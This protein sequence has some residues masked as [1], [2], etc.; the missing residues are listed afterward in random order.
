MSNKEKIE[1]NNTIFVPIYFKNKMFNNFK[2]DNN[3][4]NKENKNNNNKFVP[5]YCK[6]GKYRYYNGTM[7]ILNCNNW[8]RDNNLR[9]PEISTTIIPYN[10]K[11]CPNWMRNIYIKYFLLK[12]NIPIEHKNK[13][14]N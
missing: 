8:F 7:D 9:K 13:S 2:E 14:V 10:C 12:N 1:N 6:N 3:T 11:Y 5:V 4:N